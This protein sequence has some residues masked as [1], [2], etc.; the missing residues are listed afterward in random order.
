ML[1]TGFSMIIGA[2]E[3]PGFEIPARDTLIVHSGSNHL[4]LPMLSDGDDGTQPLTIE[5][6]SFN[7]SLLVVDSVTFSMGDQMALIWVSELGKTGPVTVEVTVSDPDGSFVGE[8]EVLVSEYPHHGINFEIHDAIFWQEVVPVNDVPV[9]GSVI[10]TTNMYLAYNSLNWNNIPLTVS[11]GCDNA[12]L[13]DGHDFCTGFLEGFLV[14]KKKGSYHFYMRGEGDYALF[15]SSDSK[16]ENASVVAA[17]SD[18]YGDVGES[19]NGRKSAAIALDSGKVYAIYAAQWNVHNEGGGIKWELPGEFSAE[20]IKG[21]FLYPKWDTERPEEIEGLEVRAI[22]DRFLRISWAKGSDDQKLKAYHIY[23]NGQKT[24]TVPETDTSIFLENLQAS[25]DYSITVSA[26]DQVDN[27]SYMQ[28]ILNVRTLERDSIPP[29]APTSLTID[30]ATGLAVSVSW[31]GALD[32][33]SSVIGYNLYLDGELY[34]PDDIILGNSAVLK[35]LTPETA[36]SLE[37]QSVDAGMNFSEKSKVFNISSTAFDPLHS[38]LGLKTGRMELSAEA[39]SYNEGIGI[40]PDFISGEMF[41]NTHIGLFKDLQPGAIRWGALTANPLSFKDYAGNRSKVNIAKFIDQCNQ[42]NAC[43]AFCCGVENSTDWRKE[44][45]TFLRFMEYINGPKNSPGGQLRYADGFTEP[46]LPNSPGLIFEFGNEVWGRSAHNAQIGA[47]Y[48]AY[49]NW[50]REMARL[51]KSSPYYDSTKI[52][53]VYS[54]R[55][56]SRE[57]SYGLND[58]IIDGGKGEV[59][60]TGPSGYLGGN[61]DYDPEFPPAESELEY[62]QNVRDRADRYLKGMV[63]SH[64]YEVEETGRLM[65]Q[66]M[67]ESNTTT[68]TY[69]GRLGQ[70]LVST[71]YYLSAMERGSAIPTIFHLTGGQWR[72]TEPENKYRRLPL[73]LTARYFNQLCKGDVLSNTYDSNQGG[74]SGT[75]ALFSERPVGAHAYRN[76]QGYSVV[77]ISRDFEDD[78]YVEIDLPDTLAHHGTG[79]LFLITGADFSTKYAVEDTT[80]VDINDSMIVKV[81]KHGM[82]ILHFQCDDIEMT[83]LPLASYPYPRIAGIEIPEGNYHFEEA[84]ESKRFSAVYSPSNSWDKEVEWTLLQNSGN[85]SLL[86]YDTHCLVYVSND[87]SNESD[88]MILRASS[89]D[90]GVSGEVILYPTNPEPTGNDIREGMLTSIYPNPASDSFIIESQEEAL[91]R[92]Y[93]ENGIEIHQ[94]TIGAGRNFIHSG[95]LPQ[96]IYAVQMGRNT[97]RLVIY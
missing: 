72:I 1:F 60:W 41:T 53:L 54:A 58:K 47:D 90:G 30:E 14:P 65:K 96:G 25:S 6:V 7:T 80:E 86:K 28:Q 27:E 32:E 77:L 67:Y 82:A 22:G 19:I 23:L 48:V 84:G 55:Y 11:A 68:P 20:D 37:I 24:A 3:L 8:L 91:L 15:L 40:N 16:F 94:E 62:Y 2:Q 17:K 59:E 97:R 83:N 74:S 61:L 51:M 56:P 44:P 95:H 35:V 50:C 52:V 57:D 88:S 79:R 64:R 45:E 21:S 81:P 12:M 33:Q 49:A 69:N 31:E 46:L 39:M 42:L 63:S 92:I 13:C 34:N 73:F 9:F 43:A 76:D 5:A 38:N 85:Y 89:R 36:Y 10:Q 78:H 75:G 66:Y 71:D 87:L 70:A 4:I 26:V 29:R 18:N 93:N